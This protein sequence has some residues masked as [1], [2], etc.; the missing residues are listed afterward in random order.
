MTDD[1]VVLGMRRFAHQSVHC[2]DVFYSHERWPQG[3]CW[4]SEKDLDPESGTVV[5]NKY[6]SVSALL[7]GHTVKASKYRATLFHLVF[8]M[9]MATTR[10]KFHSK[11]IWSRNQVAKQHS[12]E[13][14]VDWNLRVLIGVAFT[15]WNE[16]F[17]RLL[18]METICVWTKLP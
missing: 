7:I 5:H 10:G 13:V 11:R 15:E 2:T 9:L 16:E 6:L 3:V 14:G 12:G 8:L 1:R 18:E 4:P 17:Q